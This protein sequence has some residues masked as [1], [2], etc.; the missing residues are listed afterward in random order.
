VAAGTKG[1]GFWYIFPEDDLG[2]QGV[3]PQTAPFGSFNNNVAH[4]CSNGFDIYD[5]LRVDE[6]VRKNV[7]YFNPA[8][9]RIRNSTWY[10]NNVGIYTGTG[11]NIRS[12]N[13]YNREVFVPTDN[14]IFENNI[15]AENK[16]SV[17][18]ASQNNIE[19]SIFIA[20]TGLG[21][22]TINNQS[23]IHMYDGAGNVSNSHIVGYDSS[24]SHMTSFAGATITY[25][26]FRFND[27]TKAN[28]LVFKASQGTINS[29]L[30]R[31]ATIYDQDGSLSGYPDN[32]LV[33]NH[34]FMLFGDEDSPSQ[35]TNFKRSTR[36]YVNTRAFYHLDDAPWSGSFRFP[37]VRVT[38]T[39]TGTTTQSVL[40]NYNRTREPILPFVVNDLNVLYTYDLTPQGQTLSSILPSQKS[41]I[42]FMLLNTVAQND[43]VIVRFEELGSLAGLYVDM[44]SD[45]GVFNNQ[46]NTSV[47]QKYSL[48]DLKN[49]QSSAYFIDG[50]DLYIK[51]VA[52]GDFSQ[53]F[54]IKWGLIGRQT[55]TNLNEIKEEKLSDDVADVLYPNPVSSKLF[56]K[57][58]SGGEALQVIDARGR[59]I[60]S[61]T[62][63]NSLDVSQLKS[64]MYILRVNDKSYRFIKE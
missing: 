39:K 5:L 33:I 52:T 60:L 35:W 48:T 17:M 54:N 37:H 63:K 13:E 28:S 22:P 3:D 41:I 14:L 2:G 36:R 46:T 15:F 64:G 6:S 32:T 19:N 20:H 18:L 10:S 7:G 58:L 21:N 16:R 1:T 50:S 27:V 8:I 56:V 55:S 29:E 59:L 24:S 30:R 42:G 47:D 26:N 51:A 4:S 57:G 45:D 12:K 43:F 23:L 31:N 11:S 9:F 40:Y 25:G 49:H 61:T 34:P 44:N 38:R 53:V 62:Y